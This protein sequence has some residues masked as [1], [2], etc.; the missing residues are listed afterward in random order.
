[1]IRLLSSAI[2]ALT[3]LFAAVPAMA[4]SWTVVYE[5]EWVEQVPARA[6]RFVSPLQAKVENEAVAAYGPFRVIDAHTAAIVDTTDSRSPA[7]FAAMLAAWPQIELL[8][9][10]EAPGTDND[11]ANLQIGRLLRA[12]GIATS[13]SAG[14]S[15]R[16]GAVELFLAGTTRTIAP[17]AEFAVH[18]W[19]D[20]D[21]RGAADYPPGSPEHRRY[22]DYYTDMGM[23]R[24]EAARFYAMTNSVPFEDALWLDGV[25]MARWI[26]Q[27]LD[28]RPATLLASEDVPRIAYLD[29]GAP[30]Q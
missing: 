9:F 22:L 6:S 15:V 29:L 2:L 14:G 8:E 19:L 30:V 1:M 27:E 3:A 20:Y 11:L 25:E 7:Q 17:G 28:Q 26:G 18:A 23:T 24:A 5:E 4:E 13:V 16:S 12:R 21:G 10:V